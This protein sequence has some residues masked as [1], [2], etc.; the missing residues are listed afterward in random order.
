MLKSKVKKG[1]YILKQQFLNKSISFITKYNTPC[2]EDL[3]KLQYGL[4]GLYLTITKMIVIL[5]LSIIFK[6][7]KE[8]IILLLLFNLLRF[9]GFGFHAKKSSQCLIFSIMCFVIL[10]LLC[11]HFS[12]QKSWL[13]ISGIL[14][15]VILGIYAPADTSN[16]PLP[17][18]KKKL[19]R[20]ITT[21]L[22]AII[23]LIISLYVPYNISLL[24]ILAIIIEMI[25]VNPL[26]YK[27]LGQ[28]Y[29]NYKH[30]D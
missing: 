21:T 1:G 15:I 29:N 12:I 3:I 10:P 13:I 24:F 27:L 20:K 8:V 9:F 7:F 5:L 28:P 16:R 25:F 14:S 19:F 17:N 23:Y 2:E 6:I 22:I 11:I 30:V 18:T 4:E 26:T